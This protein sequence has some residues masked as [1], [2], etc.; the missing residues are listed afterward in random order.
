[1]LNV[2]EELDK[3]KDYVVQQSKSNLTRLKKNS[4]KNLYNS[5]KGEA[6]AMPNSFY[7]SF[8][9][10]EY[11]AYVDKGVKGAD[12]SQVSPN[13]KVKGQQAP[14]SP[15]SFKTKKPPSDLI[16]KWAQRKNLRLR[17]K[18][19]QYIKGSYKAIGFITAKNIWAR[20][21]K[22]SLFFTKPFQK[23]FEKLPQ[24]LIVKYG[25]DVEE[26]FKHTIKQPK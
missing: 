5:I 3:F 26:L 16:A 22:P 1:M 25:L 8:D 17:N 9:L 13:A 10:G 7:L 20:G 6:K 11:G 21:I 15:Y 14:N 19:G 23:Y 24:E 18:K 4:S 2:Q 12:P